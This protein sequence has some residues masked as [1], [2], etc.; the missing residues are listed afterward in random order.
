MSN[1]P[2]LKGWIPLSDPR[3]MR[4]NADRDCEV[5]LAKNDLNYNN[6]NNL[7]QGIFIKI[8]G[9]RQTGKT[10]LLK[11]IKD[12]L[13]KQK[14]QVGFLDFKSA[15]FCESFND[16]DK[17]TNIFLKSIYQ[18]FKELSHVDKFDISDLD[19]FDFEYK[20]TSYLQDEIFKSQQK[21]P[22]IL[23]IDNFQEIFATESQIFLDILR[24]WFDDYLKSDKWNRFS[25][26]FAYSV[27]DYSDWGNRNSPFAN[28]DCHKIDLYEFHE[29]QILG[30]A[31]NYGIEWDGGVDT[32]RQL[33]N[34]IGGHPYLVNQALY[35]IAHD[36]ISIKLLEQQAT[37]VQSP[38]YYH[39]NDYEKILNKPKNKK[40][41]QLFLRIINEETIEN[42]QVNRLLEIHLLKMG[43]IKLDA[44]NK[45]QV[46]CELY[47]KYFQ[48][49]VWDDKNDD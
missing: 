12:Y 26:I 3:Y 15:K 47:Q 29:N 31:A 49:I 17:F 32:A 46:R 9:A 41:R 23:I 36:D 1:L 39:L 5:L 27:E 37:S 25:V 19:D 14:C 30:L 45:P 44:S 28:V 16:L 24:I 43:L 22:I 42:S 13:L 8:Q 4:T 35:K 7:E 18:E 33:K 2:A 48:D 34:F 6:Y 40:V 21:Q 38:F 20:L 10:S 11:R